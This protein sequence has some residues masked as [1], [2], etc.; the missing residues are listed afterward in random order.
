MTF[1]S[2]VIVRVPD[3][4]KTIKPFLFVKSMTTFHTYLIILHAFTGPQHSLMELIC[5]DIGNFRCRNSAAFI[6]TC[7]AYKYK[8]H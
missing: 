3:F 1:T 7:S 4:S 8:W 6:Q 5:Y 2:D